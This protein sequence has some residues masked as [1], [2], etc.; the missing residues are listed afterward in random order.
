MDLLLDGKCALV[1][2]SSAGIGEAIAR[3]LAN[4]G[5]SVII[6]GRNRDRAQKVCADI[7]A[8]GGKAV[9][10]IGDLADDAQAEAVVTEASAAFGSVD[11]L[12]NNAGGRD[13]KA[14]TSWFDLTVRDWADTYNG[15]V[16][17]AVR[18]IQAFA[19]A[20]RSRGWGRI[21][22]ISSLGG[23]SS[24]GQVA[25]YAAAK[26]AMTN[27]TVGLA[28]AL[29]KTGVTVNTISPGLVRTAALEHLLRAV[30]RREG[31][32]DDIEAGARWMLDNVMPQSVDRLGQPDDIAF[33]AAYLASP[34]SDFVNGANFRIDGGAS[35]SEN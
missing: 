7:Q 14:S 4:E 34:R 30:A 15:N 8:E 20:M 31:F 1:T 26:G 32:G 22:N 10:V 17:A 33:A 6:H 18:M 16:I 24:S 9:A 28:K 13:D 11:I 3:T 35:T 21:I 23:H 12:I 29:G 5:A 27:M 2:G 25:E 19:P